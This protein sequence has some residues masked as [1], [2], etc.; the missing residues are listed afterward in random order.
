MLGAWTSLAQ[1]AAAAE[2]VFAHGTAAAQGKV[3][4]GVV[5]AGQTSA[6][7]PFGSKDSS[8]NTAPQLSMSG[9]HDERRGLLLV[10]GSAVAWS[11][12]G[13]IARYLTVSDSWTVVFWRS[14]F[15]SAFLL[16]FMFWQHA[17]RG[18]QRLVRAMGW[19]GVGVGAAVGA[20]G[21]AQVG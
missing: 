19:A 3:S 8:P 7:V 18:T 14:V 20:E 11:F 10:F 1:G 9:V 15:A 2:G 6:M 13:A 17:S 5:A 4:G 12:G 21:S 16:A